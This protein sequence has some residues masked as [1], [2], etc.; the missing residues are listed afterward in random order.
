MSKRAGNVI[1]L[2]DLVDEFGIDVVR[3]FFIEKSLNTQMTFD[4]A[5]AREK[6][7]KNPVYYAQYAHARISAIIEKTKN[8]YESQEGQSFTDMMKIPS[9]RA[10]AL[11]ISELPEVIADAAHDY[12]VHSITTYATALASAANACYRDMRVVSD[13]SFDSGILALFVRARE[14]ISDT[15]SILGI[16][17]PERM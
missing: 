17:S 14:T 13:D 6:S 8:L 12:S 3:W 2:R 1:F 10:L 4:M 9:A 11:K 16:S 15:L 7:D 5:L